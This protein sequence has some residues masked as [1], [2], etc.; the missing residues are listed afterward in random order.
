MATAG[1]LLCAGWTTQTVGGELPAG[2][3]RTTGGRL[4]DLGTLLILAGLVVAALASLRLLA[5]RR[6]R[7]AVV[8]LG[9]A[10]LAIVPVLVALGI[11]APGIGQRAFILVGV[12]WQWCFA[13]AAGARVR[14]GGARRTA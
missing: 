7:L 13:G 9:V 12:A 2:V 4:H 5:G 3:R 11:G 1:L 6:Y 14:W 8:G 10:L